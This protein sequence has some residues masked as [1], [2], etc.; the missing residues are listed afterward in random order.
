MRSRGGGAGDLYFLLEHFLSCSVVCK[1]HRFF[2]FFFLTVR[3]NDAVTW[4]V[5]CEKGP[6]GSDSGRAAAG[7][8]T[9]QEFW[10]PGRFA[11]AEP[12]AGR[13]ASI[14]LQG[15][16][17]KCPP[18]SPMSPRGAAAGKVPE[19]LAGQRPGA[20]RPDPQ[21]FTHPGVT[22]RSPVIQKPQSDQGGACVR[23]AAGP[24]GPRGGSFFRP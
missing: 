3:E 17:G 22:H 1:R 4:P 7:A 20:P 18:Q 21:G 12:H 9:G 8:L 23:Q 14:P 15:Q 6:P 5:V 10:A 11:P 16:G 2:F 13:P 19:H 24:C